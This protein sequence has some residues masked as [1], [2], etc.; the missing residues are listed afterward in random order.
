MD[1]TPAGMEMRVS[2]LA[3]ENAKFPMDVSLLPAAKVMDVRLLALEN[4]LVPMDVT[5]AGIVMAVR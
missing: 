4:A 2:A 3:P 5:P 1:V